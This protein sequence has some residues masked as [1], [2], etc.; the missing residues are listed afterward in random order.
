MAKCKKSSKRPKAKHKKTSAKSRHDKRDRLD[1]RNPLRRV[2]S[3]A[4]VPLIGALAWLVKPL[5]CVLDLRIGFR[6]A[7]VI[8]GIWPCALNIPRVGL[9]SRTDVA[10]TK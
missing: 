1:R 2:T 7:I 5:A 3:R 9:R 10:V 6:L 4:I 8:S